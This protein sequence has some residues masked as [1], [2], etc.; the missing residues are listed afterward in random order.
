VVARRGDLLGLEVDGRG[1]AD[2]EAVELLAGAYESLGVSRSTFGSLTGNGS[3]A[4]V[5]TVG[6]RFFPVPSQAAP[7]GFWIGPE[8]RVGGATSVWMPGAVVTT[9]SL[10]GSAGYAF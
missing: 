6:A 7:R 5:G 1:E 2:A 10:L 4:F 8:A 9:G 3:I